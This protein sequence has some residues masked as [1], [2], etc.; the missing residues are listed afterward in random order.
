M[1][2]ALNLFAGSRSGTLTKE[3]LAAFQDLLNK[4]RNLPEPEYGKIIKGAYSGFTGKDTITEDQT[5]KYEDFLKALG[6]KSPGEVASYVTQDLASKPENFGYLPLSEK[7]ESMA[8]YYGAP[9]VSNGK[10]TGTYGRGLGF[11]Q[12]RPDYTA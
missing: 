8:A 10:F 5:K 7:A 9:N 1:S 3:T 11:I 12:G 2:S 6:V 4:T